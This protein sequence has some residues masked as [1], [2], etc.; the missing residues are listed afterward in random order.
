MAHKV[1][2]MIH[3]E[4]Q[5]KGRQ[6]KLKSKAGERFYWYMTT[7]YSKTKEKDSYYNNKQWTEKTRR[8]LMFNHNN[9]TKVPSKKPVTVAVAPLVT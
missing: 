3:K 8:W 5:F 1:I 9:K 2:K 6:T 4:Y 7:K